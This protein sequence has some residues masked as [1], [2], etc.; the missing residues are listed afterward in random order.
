MISL[1]LGALS[2]Y[3]MYLRKKKHEEKLKELEEQ[4]ERIWYKF[5]FVTNENSGCVDHLRLEMPCRDKCSHNYL[6]KIRRHLRSAKVSISMCVYHVTLDT[7]F[8]ELS[9]AHAHRVKVRVIA[10]RE[11]A[12]HSASIMKKLI[13]RGRIFKHWY[14]FIVI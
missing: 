7:V 8:Q 2:L 11:M 14:V 5:M 9:R 1:G 12:H 6:R 10:D 13:N 3:L 4:S